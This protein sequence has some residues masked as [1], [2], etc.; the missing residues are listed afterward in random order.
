M[1]NIDTRTAIDIA[2]VNLASALRRYKALHTPERKPSAPI[3]RKG[4]TLYSVRR[5]SR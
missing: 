3:V 1:S 4:A 2:A 5:L